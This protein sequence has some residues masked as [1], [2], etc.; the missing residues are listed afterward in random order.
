MSANQSNLT[1]VRYGYDIVLATT[2]AS[3]NATMKTYLRK[4]GKRNKEVYIIIVTKGD[5]TETELISWEKLQQQVPGVDPFSIPNGATVAQND[6]ISKLSDCNFVAGIKITMGLPQNYDASKLTEIPNIVNIRDGASNVD[7]TM[8][9]SELKIAQLSYGKKGPMPWLA[10]SQNSVR[11]RAW[12]A[13][14]RV[15]LRLDSGNKDFATLPPA[16]QEQTKNLSGSM[17]SVEQLLF[18]LSNAR[19]STVPKFEGLDPGSDAANLLS[20]YFVGKYFDAM[21]KSGEPVLNYTVV[22]TKQDATLQPTNLNFHVSPL[23]KE[24]N[25]DVLT[26]DYLVSTRPDKYLPP[27]VNFTWDWMSAE[28]AKQA[29]GVIAINRDT[30]R[31][32]VLDK[33]FAQAKRQC[34]I[35]RARCWLDG[36]EIYWTCSPDY[37]AVVDSDI[38]VTKFDRNS[39]GKLFNLHFNKKV[40]DEAGLGGGMGAISLEITYDCVAFAKGNKLTFNSSYVV[41][42]FVRNAQNRNGADIVNKTY[43]DDIELVVDKDGKMKTRRISSPK[44]QSATDRVG[45][46]WDWWAPVNDVFNTLSTISYVGTDFEGVYVAE[47][48]HFVFPGGQTFAFKGFHF[49]DNQDLLC[50]ITYADPTP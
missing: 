42:L 45:G 23:V 10:L 47:L 7:F 18:D 8:L 31:Q 9:C 1:D 12:Y 5:T 22:R 16:V 29:H 27:A 19:L 25:P 37:G 21:Q 4:L 40:D 36:L 3:I 28:D 30:F 32:Y 34:F 17:F 15:D 46:F 38:Q 41:H 35:P 44:D 33:V 14:S 6:A 50:S 43:N 39:E 20:K 24:T 26:L 49:S 48:G 11:N 2:Q 13:K